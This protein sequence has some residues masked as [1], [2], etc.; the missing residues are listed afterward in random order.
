[1]YIA[2]YYINVQKWVPAINRLKNYCKNYDKTIFIEEALHRLSRNSLS[3]RIRRRS[4]K[5]C[6]VY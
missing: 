4:K 3:F 1:M 6:K 2:K 5:I